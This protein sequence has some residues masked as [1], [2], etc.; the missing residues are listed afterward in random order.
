MTAHE[1][2]DAARTI[3]SVIGG[4]SAIAN[5]LPPAAIFADYPRFQRFYRTFIVNMFAAVSL[6]IRAQYPSLAVKM[7]G[8]TQPALPPPEK[9]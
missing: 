9:K 4:A 1:A 7:F 2:W 8:L 6:S 5:L 3:G